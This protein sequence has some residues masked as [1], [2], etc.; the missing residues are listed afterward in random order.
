MLA[1]AHMPLRPSHAPAP[2]QVVFSRPVIA[3]GGDFGQPDNYGGKVPFNLTC[4][5]PGKFRWVTT[6]IARWVAGGGRHVSA[7]AA[8]TT[9]TAP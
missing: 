5:V 8:T 2:T 9:T 4:D 3:L 7:C 6:I 1:H